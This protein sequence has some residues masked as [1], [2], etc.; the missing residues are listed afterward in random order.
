MKRLLIG[1]V[2]SIFAF[3]LTACFSSSAG[4]T[5]DAGQDGAIDDVMGPETGMP[6]A[7][8]ETST[9]D[10]TVGDAAADASTADSLVG[11][12]PSMDTSVGDAPADALSD[13]YDGGSTSP[14]TSVDAGGVTDGGG[15]ASCANSGPGLSNCGSSAE[16]CCTSLEVPCG[17]YFR[18]Y[19]F[20]ADG[21][22]S[23]E[24]YPATISGFRLDKYDVT[25][26]RFRQF[27]EA[28]LPS[29]GGP[30]WR[31][32][33]GSGKHSHLNGGLGLVDTGNSGADGS[34][35]YEPG[36]LVANDG[37]IAPTNSNLSDAVCDPGTSYATWTASAGSNEN[38]PI[39]CMNWFE[40]YAFCIWDGGFL[41]SEA[42]WEYVAAGGDQQLQYPWGTAALGTANQYAVFGDGSGAGSS[43]SADCYYPSGALAPCTGVANI[44]PVGTAT[45]GAGRWGQLDLLGNVWQVNLDWYASYTDPCTDCALLTSGS[46]IIVARGGSFDMAS[47]QLGPQVR[48]YNTNSTYR[49]VRFGF[50]CARTP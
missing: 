22:L 16:S 32:A 31:P 43:V 12:A 38:R 9:V 34:T 5:V 49:G 4:L 20:D 29:D 8:P 27:V 39:N 19:N 46:T 10:S 28:V 6:D 26:G 18:S 41:P 35:S 40:A 1:L 11:D 23:A 17:T 37:Q 2:G 42:E 36:W 13:V 25:V 50:R 33:A 44:A 7:A 24:D 14:C 3:A 15:A 30:G 21:G 47:G 45:L 48:D